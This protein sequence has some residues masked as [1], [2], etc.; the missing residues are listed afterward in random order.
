MLGPKEGGAE[1]LVRG[2]VPARGETI[3]LPEGSCRVERRLA[4]ARYLLAFDIAGG[5]PEYLERFGQMPTPPYIKKRLEAPQRYQTV[6]AGPPGSVAAPTAGLHFTSAMLEALT[7]A[8]V[9]IAYIT[10]TSARRP[11]SR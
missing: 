10:C 6:Y 8:G 5:L 7:A 1:A 4:G 3:R 9:G 2:K 11:S